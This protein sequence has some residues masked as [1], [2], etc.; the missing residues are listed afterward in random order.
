[1]DNLQKYD[2]NFLL[3]NQAT[4]LYTF[5]VDFLVI[6]KHLW[7]VSNLFSVAF[8]WELNLDFWCKNTPRF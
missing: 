5:K 7:R 8:I 2:K 4:I 1:M 6:L 3:K